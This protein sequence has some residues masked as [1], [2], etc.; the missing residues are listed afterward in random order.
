[1]RLDSSIVGEAAGPLEQ[2]LDARW[3]MAYSAGLGETD[4]RYYDTSSATGIAA[5]PLFA[6]QEY[7]ADAADQPLGHCKSL[8]RTWGEVYGR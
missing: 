6:V 5:H 4:A 1:M 8:K 3:I 2:E 7:Q